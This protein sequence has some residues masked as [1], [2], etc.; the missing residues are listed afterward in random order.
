MVSTPLS[1]AT[2]LPGSTEHSPSASGAVG[3]D[4]SPVDTSTVLPN[5]ENTHLMRD[6]VVSGRTWADIVADNAEHDRRE[7][8]RI[9]TVG[10][11]LAAGRRAEL[12][13]LRATTPELTPEQ[14][15]ALGNAEWHER[16]AYHALRAGRPSL[17]QKH[18]EAA[19]QLRN[20][21][22]SEG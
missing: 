4:V 14:R 13:G 5:G 8:D 17:A 16:R 21:I 1:T 15:Q 2:A 10:V 18:Q 11:R 7:M 22:W 9:R 20:S 12:A 6:R 19:L 3:Q